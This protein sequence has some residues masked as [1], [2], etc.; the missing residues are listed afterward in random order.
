[1]IDHISLA[2][3]DL[4]R[5]AAF[6]ERVLMPLALTKLVAR[7]GLTVGFGKRYPEFWLN[8]R[9]GLA[10][11]P[12]TTG[13]HICLRAASEEAVSAFHAAALANGGRDAGEPGPRQAAFTTYFGA[14][15]FDPD[16]N[17][18]EAVHFPANP[19]AG[20]EAS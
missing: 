16:G 2:V 11:Q 8:M 13:S 20:F 5:S 15:I 9:L 10:P 4:E 19:G 12:E 17:K 18:I 3:S 1:M 6:Y 7:G 14:F